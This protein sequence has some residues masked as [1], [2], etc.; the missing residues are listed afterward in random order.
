MIRLNFW[1]LGPALLLGALILPPT[2]SAQVSLG[3][4]APWP[5]NLTT[6]PGPRPRIQTVTGGFVVNTDSREQA[7][8]FYNAI[9]PTS[10]NVPINSTAD[11]SNCVPGTNALSFQQAALRRINWFR[12]MAGEPANV[13]YNSTYNS[14]AQQMAV[15]ISKNNQLNH[16]PPTSWLCYTADGAS[17]ATGNQAYGYNGAE[18][19][20]GYIWDF[21][22]GNN[23]VGHRRW[24]LYPQEQIMG[25]GDVPP[26][27]ASYLAANL[28]YVFDS[29][30]GGTRPATRQPYVAW[31]PEGF[32]PYPVVYP[33]WS[34]ALTNANFTNAT[35]TMRSNGVSVATSIQPY[36]IYYG[37][38][39]LVWVPMG[40]DATSQGTTFPFNG[41]DTVYSVTVTNIKAGMITTGFTYTVTVF[42]PAVPGTDYVATAVSGTNTPY[43]NTTNAY[44]CTPL[45]N[46]NVS[47]YLWL[48]AQP[49]NGNLTDNATNGLTNFT[50]VPAP[51]YSVITNPP[52]GTGKCFHLCHTNPVSQYLQMNEVI[53]PATNTTF[54]FSSLLGFAANTETASVQASP[55]GG[56]TWQNLFVESGCYNG[57]GSPSQCETTFT[58]HTY[59]LSNY[60][61]HATLL[62]FVY[63]LPG[64]GIYFNT[65]DSYIGWCIENIVVTNAQQAVN[66]ATNSTVAT[67]F[68]FTPVQTGT[69]I[70]AV[71]PV[72]FSQFPVGWGITKQVTVVTNPVQNIV[73][74]LPVLTNRQ[75]QI[76]FTIS[77]ATSTFHLVQTTNLASKWTTNSTAK[78]TTNI[79]GSSYSY[80]ATNNL[81]ANFFRVQTP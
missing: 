78:L 11:V 8:D 48:T 53:L 69:N 66:L 75:L 51:I 54:S 62:R 33:Y 23:E 74:G 34:F 6:L 63:A 45:A 27:G 22:A 36:Q 9:Y 40:L 77:G 73:L 5:T 71:A 13:V 2:A 41:T 60:V 42:D 24:I 58:P 16:N 20:S 28:T 67:N 17:V 39:T 25:T 43:L 7:R 31:P 1:L 38:N 61:G 30:I 37:E 52:A 55:D 57:T 12:A 50:I 72:L 49:T 46:A 70:L 15:M 32:V 18:A 29:S 80:T 59:S 26:T 3:E 10:D 76:N 21:G 4:A 79:L 68:T 35:V 19:I 81:P 64:S 56:I 65:T 44:T 47:N 14:E